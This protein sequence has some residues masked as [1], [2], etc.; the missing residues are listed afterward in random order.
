MSNTSPKYEQLAGFM[1]SLTDKLADIDTDLPLHAQHLA[2]LT[3]RLSGS[4]YTFLEITDGTK[5]EYVKVSN[6]N[7]KLYLERGKEITTPTT[8]P[9]GSCVK[10]KLTPTAIRDIICQMPCCPTE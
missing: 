10:W 2:E 7:N 9:V 6:V 3:S 5:I 1:S 8:F 4:K